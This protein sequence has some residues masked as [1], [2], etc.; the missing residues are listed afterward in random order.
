M[1]DLTTQDLRRGMEPFDKEYLL[2]LAYQHGS[3]VSLEGWRPSKLAASTPLL[4]IASE[5][6][7]TLPLI[8]L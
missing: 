1:V 4:E 7:Q 2:P 3:R 8:L 6:K 5:L